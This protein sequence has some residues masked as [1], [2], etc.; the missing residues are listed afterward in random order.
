MLAMLFE[1]GSPHV[2]ICNYQNKD[3]ENHQI[4]PS[5]VSTALHLVSAKVLWVVEVFCNSSVMLEEGSFDFGHY[6]RSFQAVLNNYYLI[7]N[8]YL[9]FS[10]LTELEPSELLLLVIA[11]NFRLQVQKLNDAQQAL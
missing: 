10:P 5:T 6:C 7:I 4:Y 1:Y 3:Y 9:T 11:S 8:T 2:E